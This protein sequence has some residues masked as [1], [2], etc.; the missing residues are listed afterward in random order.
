M[1]TQLQSSFSCSGQT[2]GLSLALPFSSLQAE[3]PLHA[4]P[5]G[6]AHGTTPD[7]THVMPGGVSHAMPGG[8][9]HA[10]PLASCAS[11]NFPLAQVPFDSGYCLPRV[12]LAD[13]LP[14]DGPPSAIYKRAV[15]D[16]SCC[17]SRQGAAVLELSTEDAALIRCALESA[18]LYF[19]T[20]AQGPGSVSWGGSGWSK[21][22]GYVPSASRDLYYYRAG[23][24]PRGDERDIPPPCMSDVF[25]CLGKAS[26]VTLGAIC[27]HLRLRSDV[28]Y[29]LLDDCP[30]PDENPS[31]SVLVATH[32]HEPGSNMRNSSG[33]EGCIQEYEKGLVTLIAS[34]SPG[35]QVCDSNGHWYLA[36]LGLRAGDILIITGKCLQHLTAGI[37]RACAYRIAPLSLS[38][39]PMSM[40]R[41]SLTFRLMPR[42]S[43]TLDGSAMSN[44]GHT[45]PENFGPVLVSKF[46]EGLNVADPTPANRGGS[47]TLPEHK[48]RLKSDNSLRTLL[49]DPLTGTILEDAFTALPCGHSFGGGTLKYV[50][51]TQKCSS[52]G[53]NVDLDRLVPNHALRAA[54]AAFRREETK[55][56][57]RMESRK[58][59]REL[60]EHGVKVRRLKENSSSPSHYEGVRY[61]RGVQYP[62][63]ENEKVVIKGN[64]R[65]PEKF[66]GREAVVTS[67]CLNGWYLL[68]TLDN[69]ESVRLQYRSLQACPRAVDASNVNEDQAVKQIQSRN[70]A[71]EQQQQ[72]TSQA[73]HHLQ[74]ASPVV[75][76]QQS[77]SPALQQQS[78][79]P[80]VH[81]AQS[82]SSAINQQQSASPV[83]HHAQSS[84]PAVHQQ[85]N[86][87]P[88]VHQQQSSTAAVHQQQSS[89]PT[90]HRQQSS[91][92]A[93]HPLRN[94][95]AAVQVQ[96]I[97]GSATQQQQVPSSAVQQQQVLGPTVQQHKIT[98]P[99]LQH[100]Q[101]SSPTA[102]HQQISGLTGQHQSVSGPAVQEQMSSPA[103]QHQL[104]TCLTI[105]Q[106]QISSPAVQ[107]QQ[108]SSP[109]VHD[110]HGPS[111]ANS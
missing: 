85:Q 102:Q 54:A 97:P 44:A 35:L 31:S 5:G 55:K 88:A 3:G 63:N 59:K 81:Q 69:G 39:N 77:S 104:S 95:T 52:C 99:M 50:T 111:L 108:S 34:D 96:Q 42:A 9:A 58:R 68:R 56:N 70:A 37:R 28:F 75:H 92:L 83:L 107:Q 78:S 101:I 13:I 100:Q 33:P 51:E 46:L 93:L 40:G 74:S 43:E 14:E 49:S 91:S 7:I 109:A 6:F 26:R 17:L 1:Q 11:P 32:Y 19:R 41:T 15:E 71:A 21:T 57:T 87:T 45:V 65:T 62:F 90:V 94:S 86:S 8:I 103:L 47:P 84:S 53:A 66:V 72:S 73:V 48:A 22:S 89:N 98:G 64:K 12:K 61:M 24:N 79:S 20:R 82:P 23:R 110:R 36:D 80:L 10:L 76:Q 30:L 60:S 38:A 106:Q 105:Q 18:T 27:R 67:K 16:L 2:S 29:P 25:R 4:M